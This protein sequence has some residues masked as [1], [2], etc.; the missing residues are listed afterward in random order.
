MI[1]PERVQ[2]LN[3]EKI[4]PEGRFVLYW[5]Q[6]SQR[7]FWNHAIEYAILRA[8]GLKLPLLVYFGITPSYPMANAR[9]YTFMAQ[10]LAQT[11]EQ[12]KDRGIPMAV[13]ALEPSEGAAR[14]GKQAALVV[15]D[16]GYTRLQR[17]W[18]MSVARALRC[19]LIQVETDVVVPVSTVSCKEEY[20]AA[21]IRP[22]ITKLLPVFLKK[23]PVYE[24]KTPS[25]DIDAP[26]TQ[27]D[28]EHTICGLSLDKKAPASRHYKGGLFEARRLFE[29]FLSNELDKYQ[30]NRNDPCKTA[31]SCMSPYLHFGQVSALWCAM[32]AINTKSH[33]AS[34][35]IEELVVRRELSMNFVSYNSQYDSFESLPGWT[36]KTLFERRSDKREYLYSLNDLENA[37]TH[38][39]YWN[40]AQKEMLI[41]GKMHGYMRMYW[42][43]K[44]LE[45]SKTPEEAYKT[46]IYLNDTY[47]IDG[48]DPNGYA[49]VAWCFG[50]HDRP[51]AGRPVFGNVR[52][53]NAAGLK[54]KFDADAYVKKIELLQNSD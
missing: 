37:K 30:E 8:N 42:G 13:E 12:L 14:I 44:I 22:K 23:P 38:D 41:T 50:K 33:G 35:F 28:P 47:E 16:C 2:R 36:R 19:P 9:H 34:A 51:W 18:R 49:G 5:M 32:E 29:N 6:A 1:Q 52:Y 4:N 45:W 31:L 39:P 46:A 7:A 24:I 53:M 17:Q 40:A 11:R 43:K 26:H 10:G 48:R 21:A 54:R 25:L 15:T 3:S 27:T 20:S